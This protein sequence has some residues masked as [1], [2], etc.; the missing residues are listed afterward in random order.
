MQDL[1]EKGDC[2]QTDNRV[3]SSFLKAVLVRDLCGTICEAVILTFLL[4]RLDLPFLCIFDPG[5]LFKVF[6]T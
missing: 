4:K 2:I 5:L 6:S 3:E 1:I